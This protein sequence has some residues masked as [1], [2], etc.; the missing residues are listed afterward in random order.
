MSAGYAAAE[1][2]ASEE[3]GKVD[4]ESVTGGIKITEI[5][6]QLEAIG[7]TAGKDAASV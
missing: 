4:W 3:V 1:K 5:R 6:K 2:S 7:T